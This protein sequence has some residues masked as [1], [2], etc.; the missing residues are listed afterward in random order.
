ML[1]D[2]IAHAIDLAGARDEVKHGAV[3]RSV[4]KHELGTARARRWHRQIGES[5]IDAEVGTTEKHYIG[6]Q[7]RLAGLVLAKVLRPSRRQRTNRK[8]QNH[9]VKV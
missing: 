7:S 8:L 4:T 9:P 6:A 1:V 5:R 2:G 3:R